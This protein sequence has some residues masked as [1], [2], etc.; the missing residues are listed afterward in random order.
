MYRDKRATK[1]KKW[2]GSEDKRTRQVDDSYH[3]LFEEGWLPKDKAKVRKI[4]IRAA[5]FVVIDDV[6]Y[7][8][9]YSLPYLRCVSS[10]E[11]DYVLREIHEGICGNHAGARSLAGKA[12]RVG[13]YWPTLQKDAY[14]IVRACDKCQCFVNVQMRPGETMTTISSPWPFA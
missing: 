13:Y 14:D 5:R 2:V 6:L 12:L 1:H 8:R 4:Q 3:P 9:G 10:V 7:R 11:V